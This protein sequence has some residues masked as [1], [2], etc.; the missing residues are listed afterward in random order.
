MKIRIA[1]RGSKLAL[2]Q[3]QQVADALIEIEPSVKVELV[4][5]RTRGDRIVDRPLSAVGGKGLFVA[6]VEAAVADGRADVAIHSLKDVPGDVDLAPGLLLASTPEREDARDVV[7]SEHGYE[8]QSLPRGARVGTCSPRRV[9]QLKAQRP[10]LTFVTL[11]GNVDTRLDKMKDGHVDA[12]VLAAAGL[13]RLG[14]FASVEPR[15]LADDICI[16]AVGQGT[17]AL[18]AR[19]KDSALVTLLARLQDT[20]TR[21]VTEAERAFLRAL[22][23]NCHC[24]I[25]GHAKLI[26]GGQR[27][28]LTAM[29]ASADGDQRLNAAA[30]RYLSDQDDHNAVAA[31]LGRQVAE[32][33]IEQGARKLIAQAHSEALAR[34]HTSN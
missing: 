7:V 8:L 9:V 10:D 34:Q 20:E 15:P 5:I 17:L 22:Q 23:G 12:I 16:P 25:A 33:L 1:T 31:E 29:V 24:P 4:Q 21:T 3:S 19:A 14:L 13:K 2:T 30:D 26:D 27:L 6:E 32:N 11:R 18:E 28:V